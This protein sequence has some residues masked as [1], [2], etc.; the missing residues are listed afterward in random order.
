M[1]KVPWNPYKVCW[2]LETRDITVI[3]AHIWHIPRSEGNLGCTSWTS[4]LFGTGYLA[5]LPCV[6][7][8]PASELLEIILCQ[9]PIS[10]PIHWNYRH[11][12]WHLYS[13]GLWETE[14]SS[15]TLRPLSHPLNHSSALP[16]ATSSESLV[17]VSETRVAMTLNLGCY[18]VSLLGACSMQGHI[19]FQA[20]KSFQIP[21]RTHIVLA[22]F[23]WRTETNSCVYKILEQMISFPSV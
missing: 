17:S 15:L 20:P 2:T 16:D 6:S 10:S 23:I 18:T 21:L 7:G 3:V 1:K 9:A 11:E 22:I 4:I 14:L 19:N 12:L 5:L 8:C 13:H